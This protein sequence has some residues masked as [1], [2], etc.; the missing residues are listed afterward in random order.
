MRG[1]IIILFCFFGAVLGLASLFI[2]FHKS[3][4]SSLR[5][6]QALLHLKSA[7]QLRSWGSRLSDLPRGNGSQVERYSAV[8]GPPAAATQADRATAS[9]TGSR[10]E[11]LARSA[12]LASLKHLRLSRLVA[13]SGASGFA[14]EQVSPGTGPMPRVETES[15]S[16]TKLIEWNT[17]Q[18]KRSL[19]ASALIEWRPR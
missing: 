4:D 9:P 3:A 17:P 18:A 6:E 2:S 7:R 15:V 13:L 19:D 5:G 14:V 8:I 1:P 11:P 16:G 12:K 10:V